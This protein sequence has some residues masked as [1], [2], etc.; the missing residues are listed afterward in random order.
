MRLTTKIILGI[1]L[2]FFLIALTFIIGFSFTDRKNFTRYQTINIQLSQ[3]KTVE[4]ELTPYKTLVVHEIQGNQSFTANNCGL[5]FHPENSSGTQNLNKLIV[6]EELK[7]FVSF[8][9][10]NDTLTIRLNLYGLTR[11]NDSDIFSIS[12]ANLRFYTSRLN[13][14]NHVRDFPVYINDIETDTI[15]IQSKG[16]IFIHSCKATL[17]D[18]VIW[19]RSKRLSV[20]NCTAKQVNIDLDDEF[21]WNVEQCQIEEQN[22]TGK[23]THSIIVHRNEKET[24]NWHPKNKDAKLNVT[25]QGDTTQLRIR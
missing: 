7:D 3:D 25:I 2:S 15:R 22:L 10:S 12:G 20:K 9:P 16:D 14:I 6:P 5:Y 8:H 1:I 24:I 18:P 19:T 13:I 11:K 4:L 21:N 23:N 17:I